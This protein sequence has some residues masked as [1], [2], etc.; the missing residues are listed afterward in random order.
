MA[1]LATRELSAAVWSSS[2]DGTS[3]CWEHTRPR[4]KIAGRRTQTLGEQSLLRFRFRRGSRLMRPAESTRDLR[5]RL[6]R[7]VKPRPSRIASPEHIRSRRTEFRPNPEARKSSADHFEA[8]SG[9][10]TSVPVEPSSYRATPSTH[11][12][13][14]TP[15]PDMCNP[16]CRCARFHQQS[17][18][19]PPA[20]RDDLSAGL[21]FPA[22]RHSSPYV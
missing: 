16:D 22:S 18:L 19:L 1:R 12:S 13:S 8:K 15:S 2:G 14:T 4:G 3:E 11:P 17:T 6:A 10:P 9:L 7:H 20:P 5:H 21:S